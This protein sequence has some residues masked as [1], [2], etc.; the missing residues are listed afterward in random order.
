MLD[1]VHSMMSQITLPKSFWDYALESVA[2]TLNIIPTKKDLVDLPPNDK[3]VGSKW[4]F[5]KKT[6]MDGNVHTYEAH[7]VAKGFTRTYGVDYEE[8]FSPIAGI[9]AIRILIAIAAFYDYEIWKMDVK[10]PS[11]M[12]ISLKRQWNKRFDDEIKKFGFTQNRDEPCI[13]MKASGSNVVTPSNWVA[14]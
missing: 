1:M 6:D 5:K 3:S 12:D 14:V 4:L 13:Y 2:R 11:S 10:L 9:R 8:T 7:L